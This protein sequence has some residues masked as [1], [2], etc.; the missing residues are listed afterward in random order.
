MNLLID[1][2]IIHRSPTGFELADAKVWP[3]MVTTA[4]P[5]MTIKGN[6]NK[7]QSRSNPEA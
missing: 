3:P 6:T 2:L 5:N 1:V 7:S 4:I